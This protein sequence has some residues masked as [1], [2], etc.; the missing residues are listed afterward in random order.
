M[1]VFKENG[2]EYVMV[3]FEADWQLAYMLNSGI[4][5]VIATPH[6]D[7]GALCSN[8]CLL[9][10]VTEDMKGWICHSDGSVLRGDSDS[11]CI[12]GERKGDQYL[13]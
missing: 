10:N 1:N 9:L 2:F 5:H 6:S 13:T 11:I 3:P 4:I 8:P 7:Y 12:K